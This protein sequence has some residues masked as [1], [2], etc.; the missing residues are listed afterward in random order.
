MLVGVMTNSYWIFFFLFFFGGITIV[1]Y[2]FFNK[3]ASLTFVQFYY[4]YIFLMTNRCKY[5][6]FFFFITKKIRVVVIY[7]QSKVHVP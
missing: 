6:D 4:L 5:C 7:K 3:S 1:Y 2:A